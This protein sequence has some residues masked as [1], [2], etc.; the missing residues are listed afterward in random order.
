MLGIARKRLYSSR[1]VET[2]RRTLSTSDGRVASERVE[3]A[4]GLND[5][6]HE[7]TDRL[8]H[9]QESFTDRLGQFP[10][11]LSDRLDGLPDAVTEVLIEDEEESQ[12]DG[13]DDRDDDPTDRADR[14]QHGDQRLRHGHDEGPSQSWRGP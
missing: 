11:R 10:E 12:D 13:R 1:M 9:G 4:Q 8:H 14:R 7:V 3:V 2:P 5:R 6:L